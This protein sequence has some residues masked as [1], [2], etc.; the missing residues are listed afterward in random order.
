ME[1]KELLRRRRE[2]EHER[3]ML[4][5][6]RAQLLL[7]WQRQL[8]LLEQV[9]L[10]REQVEQQHIFQDDVDARM[11]RVA[12][13]RQ[14]FNNK[15]LKLTF[16]RGSSNNK[17]NWWMRIRKEKQI[18][19]LCPWSKQILN[20]FVTANNNKRSESVC[21][22]E[23]LIGNVGE[24]YHVDVGRTQQGF[25][26]IDSKSTRMHA[27]LNYRYSCAV[28]P[29]WTRN[30]IV[31]RKTVENRRIIEQPTIIPVI[32]MVGFL[33]VLEEDWFT[34]SV[35][36]TKRGTQNWSKC[37]YETSLILELTLS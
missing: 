11:V 37:K 19:F 15:R 10:L 28:D 24:E 17:P 1:R 5:Q 26:T 18:Q 29:S 36:A 13:R 12:R 21:V 2:F 9:R 30:W 7:E 32:P 8:L 35:N 6:E 3:Q 4:L 16:S 33:L 23:V 31:A 25:D 22:M 14:L 20:L 27:R 34:L